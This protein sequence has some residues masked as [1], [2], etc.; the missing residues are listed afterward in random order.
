VPPAEVANVEPDS[1]GAGERPAQIAFQRSEPGA[2]RAARQG[3]RIAAFETPGVPPRVLLS[4][5]AVLEATAVAVAA[6]LM[7]LVYIDWIIGTGQSI[8]AYLVLGLALAATLHLFY[9]QL[10]LYEPA[11]LSQSSVQLGKLWGGLLLS[12][13]VL[14]GVLYLLRVVE[15]FSRGWMLLWFTA[16]ALL[17]GVIRAWVLKYSRSAVAEGRMRD[18]VAIFGSLALGRQLRDHLV[19]HAPHL[20]VVGLFVEADE[21]NRSS[22]SRPN[23][24]EG[25]LE[26]LSAIARYGLFDRVLIALPATQRGTIRETVKR[27]ALLPVELHLCC[28]LKPAAVPVYG[29]AECADLRLDVV[30]TRPGAERA[31]FL[32]S[33]FD[34]TVAIVGLTC[35]SPLIAVIAIAI[36]ASS[37]GPI[38][39]RQR[40]YGCNHRVINV[41]KFRTMKVIEDGQ[42]IK[43]VS[44]N[45]P[46]VTR[47]GRLLRRTSLDELPQLVNVL[48]GEMSIVGP[49]PHAIAHNEYF[50][51]RLELYPWRHR[52]KPG[53]TGWAQVHGLRGETRTIEDMRRRVACDLYYIENWSIWLDIE[54][55]LRTAVALAR[56]QSA[57]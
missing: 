17:L 54:I 2:D 31:T 1:N 20:E 50:A 48:K 30:M 5:L 42:D 36:K 46:R 25:G 51:G 29:V 13:L 14:L 33:T 52:V 47:L 53:I 37:G 4:R 39:F 6:V 38:F 34:Y 55:L 35:L 3:L 28:D 21:A 32:K 16:A 9:A 49:R 57:Y 12:F 45:D 40:R 10:G 26:K 44:P 7:K 22:D 19:V 24:V 23:D 56:G 8:V 15:W 43:Q 27:L 18:R 41:Y 11:F